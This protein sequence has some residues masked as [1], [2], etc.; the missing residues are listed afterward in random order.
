MSPETPRT[1]NFKR[2]LLTGTLIG[3]VAGIVFG[4][5]DPGGPSYPEG[6]TFDVGTAVLFLAALGAFLGAGVAGILAVLLDRTG[7][8][9]S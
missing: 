7:R 8:G 4:L 2:F 3:L 6:K 5:R 9:R 1:P